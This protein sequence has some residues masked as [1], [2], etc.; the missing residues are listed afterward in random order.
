MELKLNLDSLKDL[1]SENFKIDAI[2]FQKMVLLFN[3][4]EDGWNIKKR[5]DSYIFTKNHEGKKEILQDSYLLRFMKSNLD[6][7]K[8]FS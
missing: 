5:D 7:N 1:E 2:K 8:L 4:L 3:A 6:M